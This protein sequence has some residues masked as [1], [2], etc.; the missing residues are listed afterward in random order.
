MSPSPPSS[1]VYLLSA[2]GCALLVALPFLAVTFPPITDLPQQAAQIRLLGEAL[3]GSDAYRVQWRDPNKLAYVPLALAWWL[4]GPLAT[5]RLAMAALGGLWVAAVH[6][7]A[8]ATGRPPAAAVLASLFFFHHATYWGFLSFLVGFPAFV[9]W[10]LVL[11]RLGSPLG[12]RDGTALLLAGFL[13]YSAHVLWLA[14][15]IVWLVAAALLDRR[16]ATDLL[17]SLVCLAPLAAAVAAWY[18]GFAASGVDARTFWGRPPW[19]RLDP[20][21]LLGAVLGGLR[22]RVEPLLALAVV[23]WLLLGLWQHRAELA[24]AGDARLA[25]AAALCAL[26]VLALPEVSRHTIFFAARWAA[27]AA[28]FAIL[29]CPP[30]RLRPL[31][32][33]AVAWLLLAALT[34]ATV[35]AWRG[36]EREELAGFEESLAAIAEDARVLGLDFVRTSPRIDGFPFYHLFAYAQVLGGGTL[37]RSFADD[38]SSLVVFRDLPRRYP[39]TDRLDWRPERLRESDRDY[40]D[41]LLVHARPEV[42]RSFLADP[43]LEALTGER[44]WRLYRVRRGG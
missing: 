41:Y 36:F 6:A 18:V 32:R 37:N 26:A 15:G 20:Q 21:W 7:L 34:A 25:L 8:R 29:A 4:A 35:V 3:A 38:A 28:V 30:P 2:A 19:V 44:P 39:W 33:D 5:G 17:R 43:H 23:A 16:P 22:G 24:A 13:L 9:V 1:R 31:L 11:R 42:Q 12:W 10:F 40:F 14:A 27:P